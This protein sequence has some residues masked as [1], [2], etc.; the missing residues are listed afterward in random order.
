MIQLQF[1]SIGN[2][3]KAAGVGSGS[4]S[5]WRP[6]KLLKTAADVQNFECVPAAA[7]ER[8]NQQ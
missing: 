3:S 5:P 4:A 8:E 7:V 6:E 1:F 2:L